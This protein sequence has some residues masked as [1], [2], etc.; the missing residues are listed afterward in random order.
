MFPSTLVRSYRTFS[1][2]PLPK[3]GAIRSLLHLSSGYPA[4]LLAST[5][6]YEA[7]TF[8]VAKPS[9]PATVQLTTMLLLTI[10]KDANLTQSYCVTTLCSEYI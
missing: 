8:L 9:R 3:T 1:P 5:M 7:R 2:S 6:P 4:W 10:T